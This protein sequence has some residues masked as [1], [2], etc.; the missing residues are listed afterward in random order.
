MPRRV[1]YNSEVGERWLVKEARLS[2][3]PAL[4]PEKP[5]SWS[6]MLTV[7][8]CYDPGSRMNVCSG[9]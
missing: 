1:W 2:N 8:L 5:A 6:R 9:Q 4:I 3:P 7:R